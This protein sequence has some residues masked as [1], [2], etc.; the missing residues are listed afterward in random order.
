MMAQTRPVGGFVLL[1]CFARGF[2]FMVHW[3]FLRHGW[4]GESSKR[5]LPVKHGAFRFYEVSMMSGMEIGGKKA[6][7]TSPL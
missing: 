7:A 3:L 5:L 1:S 4:N 6:A 2:C